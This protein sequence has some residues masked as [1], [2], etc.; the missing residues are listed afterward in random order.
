MADYCGRSRTIPDD[1]SRILMF[2][3]GG[4]SKTMDSVAM[5]LR[6]LRDRAG[7]PSYQELARATAKQGPRRQM[8]RGSVHDKLSGRSKLRLGQVLAIA[9][10]CCDYA[11]SVG[12][13][14]PTEFKTEEYWRLRF[15]E[16]ERRTEALTL[17]RPHKSTTSVIDT[18][19]L[20]S[21]GMRDMVDLVE[22]SIDRP[23][24]EWLPSVIEAAFTAGLEVE[25]YLNVAA[26]STPYEFVEILIS[27]Q[28]VFPDEG[29]NEVVRRLIYRCAQLQEPASL[30]MVAAQL[31]RR[32]R[33]HMVH[34]LLQGMFIYGWS[35]TA[36]S[37]IIDIYSC[38]TRATMASDAKKLLQLGGENLDIKELI[39]LAY[40]LP[41]NLFGPKDDVL[42][43][44]PSS[45]Y[46]LAYI[47]RDL[48]SCDLPP[49]FDRGEIADRMIFGIPRGEWSQY[50]AELRK[51]EMPE[52]AD[53]AAFLE[54]EPPF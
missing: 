13:S 50:V 35:R 31:R 2:T 37:D 48:R 51:K 43:S 42:S 11:E 38:F 34:S 9:F 14:L 33:G 29:S 25:S 22:V 16:G 40:R 46:R 6:K 24:A 1:R 53:R 7:G 36:R 15:S 39:D 45:P 54:N 44:V 32:G 23:L 20:A 18:Q 19:P 49:G 17:E 26:T 41:G 21:A 3:A 4:G 52:E 10:A 28:E 12:I 5:Q 47:L 30:P 27:L 8:S